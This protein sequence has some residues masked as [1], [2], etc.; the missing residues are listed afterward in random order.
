MTA[1]I[2]AVQGH[3]RVMQ[4]ITHVVQSLRALREHLGNTRNWGS[5]EAWRG[6]YEQQFHTFS[7]AKER[8]R[9]AHMVGHEGNDRHDAASPVEA[10]ELFTADPAGDNA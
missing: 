1:L 10:V 4:G 7:M 5:A 6:L 2:I 3:D 9:F 8:A